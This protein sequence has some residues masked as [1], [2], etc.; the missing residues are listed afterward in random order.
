MNPVDV[1]AAA[2][3]AARA[4]TEGTLDAVLADPNTDAAL[5]LILAIEGVDFPEVRQVFQGLKERHPTKPLYLVI[6]GSGV[7]TRWL[8]DLEGLDIPVFFNS[9]LAVSALAAA[10]R[11]AQ[12]RGAR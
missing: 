9:R 12:A 6:Y 1:W 7:K 8:H 2:E 11:Y 4:V 10:T 3:R 5:A